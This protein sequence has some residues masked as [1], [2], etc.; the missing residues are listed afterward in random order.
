MCF[1]SANTKENKHDR[2]FIGL[3]TG[4]FCY[5]HMPKVNYTLKKN[6]DIDVIWENKKEPEGE[7]I[8]CD[9]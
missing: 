2:F 1:K 8:A 7:I 5:S 4:K 9:Y 3:K 6:V